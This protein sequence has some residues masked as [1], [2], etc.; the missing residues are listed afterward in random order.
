MRARVLHE[1]PPANDR[2]ETRIVVW[3]MGDEKHASGPVTETEEWKVSK[4]RN[5]DR[6]Q[7]A[8]GAN[9]ANR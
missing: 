9:G 4:V 6:E 1:G 3:D 7:R 5:R 8:C 2:G